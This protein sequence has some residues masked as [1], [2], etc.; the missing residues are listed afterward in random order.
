M[1]CESLE[2]VLSACGAGGDGD[3]GGGKAKKG[4]TAVK[5]CQGV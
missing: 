3:E 1:L 5:V 4:G 2:L